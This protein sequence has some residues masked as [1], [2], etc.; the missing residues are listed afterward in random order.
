[1]SSLSYHGFTVTARTYQLRG[2]G[3]WTLEVL[4]GRNRALRAFTSPQTYADESAA[5]AACL[6]HGR[7]IIDGRIR[8]ISVADLR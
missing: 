7:L 2:S 5:I 1:M 6:N 4:I 3:R 8:G